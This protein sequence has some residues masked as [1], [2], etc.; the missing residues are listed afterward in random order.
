[1]LLYFLSSNYKTNAQVSFNNAD[2]NTKR[3]NA[4]A[5]TETALATVGIIG[6]HYLWYKK[7]PHSR[8]HFFNDSKEW[9]NMDKMGH[10]TTAYN[11]CAIQYNMMQ[12]GGLSNNRSTWIGGLTAM[13]LQSIIEIFDG[14][15]QKWGF[16][17]TDML[18]NLIGTTLFMTQQFVY[19]EQRFQLKFSFHHSMFAAYNPNELGQNKWQR[20]LKDYNGQ[21]YWLSLN[22][23]TFMKSTTDFPKWLNVSFGHSATGM[24][25]A[26]ENPSK[27]GNKNIPYFKRQRKYLLSLDVNLKRLDIS[28]TSPKALLSL[29]SIIKFPTPTFQL[30]KDD[31]VKFHLLYF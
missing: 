31:N 22:P 23:S 6:L 9:L 21:T 25:G 11:L 18:A 14:F 29:P 30:I 3:V 28:N 10:A 15:S 2:Y 26:T 20:W 7:F 16:S 4:I 5:I 27:I 17:K 19:K 1:M 24:I 8:F 12:W 13:G